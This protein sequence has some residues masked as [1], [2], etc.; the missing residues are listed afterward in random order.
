MNY[1]MQ[2]ILVRTCALVRTLRLEVS[3]PPWENGLRSLATPTIMPIISSVTMKL[4][5]IVRY[6]SELLLDVVAANS[7]SAIA[8]VLLY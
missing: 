7:T 1:H 2:A 3:S 4:E 8:T 5:W 6:A